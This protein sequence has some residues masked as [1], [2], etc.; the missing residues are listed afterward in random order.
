MLPN[1]LCTFYYVIVADFFPC[2]C[3]SILHYCNHI[4]HLKKKT[5]NFKMKVL[6]PCCHRSLL[7]NF[8]MTA[9]SNKRMHRNSVTPSSTLRKLAPT[10]SLLQMILQLIKS[11]MKSISH[12]MS[13]FFSSLGLFT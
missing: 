1:T 3:F 11:C 4:W 9:Y 8:W 5:C 2:A 13:T 12:F 7:L 6:L 10:C